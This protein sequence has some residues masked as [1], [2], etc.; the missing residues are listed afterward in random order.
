MNAAEV[1]V[2]LISYLAAAVAYTVLTLLLLTSW[3]GRL[4][5]G[6]LVSACVLSI[7]WAA[8]SAYIADSAASTDGRHVFSGFY[9]LEVLRNWAWY[10]FLFKLLAPLRDNQPF[11][12]KLFR[13][14]VAGVALF[15]VLVLVLDFLPDQLVAARLHL[16]GL[17]P[18]LL[19]HFVMAVFGLVL[20]EQLFRNTREDRRWAV[21]FLFLGVGSLFIYDF[22][23]YADALLFRSLDY[24]FWQARGLVNAAVV[25]LLAISAARNNEW[26]LDVFVSRKVVFHT[27]TLLGAGLYLIAMSLAG[28][29]IRDFGGSWGTAIQTAFLF[30]AAL[31]LLAMLF[32]GQVRSRIKVFLN[33]HFFSYSYDYRDEWLKLSATLTAKSQGRDTR[34]NAIKALADIVESP[35]GMLFTRSDAGR[36]TYSAHWN[37]DESDIDNIAREHP[38]MHFMEEKNWIVDLTNLAELTQ[39]EIDAELPEWLMSMSRAWLLLP[40]L[41]GDTMIGFV[42]LARPRAPKPLDW[43]SRDLLKAVALQI[44]SHIALLKTSEELMNARQFEAFNRLSSYVVHDL[45]NVTAQLSLI[46]TNAKRFRNN[47]DF[48]KDAFATVENAVS[49]INRML[50]QLRKGEGR[51]ENKDVVDV[52]GVLADVVEICKAVEPVPELK[53]STCQCEVITDRDRLLNVLAHIVRNAQEATSERGSVVISVQCNDDDVV[54][55]ITDD[56]CGMD[57]RFLRERLFKPFD[58]TKGN[59]G[60]GIGVYECREFIW[61]QGGDV[62]VRSN[63]G[64]GT[65]FCISLPKFSAAQGDDATAAGNAARV[66]Q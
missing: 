43:E 62:T 47:P 5:G 29:Y 61:S 31:L 4:Q 56:G 60:M 42:V 39:K 8:Y 63:P 24:G 33:K 22:F 36:Y 18:R 30:F 40:L 28:I 38:V 57:E 35:G 52:A 3:R 44:A 64:E 55:D 53:N 6:L 59:A 48:V 27:V 10:L 32:S 19:G 49:K 23:M 9:L 66:A 41:Q 14:A 46:V 51:N 17:N 26:S 54:V 7:A 58:T 15:S 1:N 50:A 45:K 25:P 16:G 34:E 21:K 20:V 12:G 65:R 2:G 37:M 11:V 13:Y